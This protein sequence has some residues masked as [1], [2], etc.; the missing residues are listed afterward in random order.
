[1]K[2]KISRDTVKQLIELLEKNDT[3][4]ERFLDNLPTP[5][6]YAILAMALVVRGDYEDFEI[7]Y[8]ESM[9]KISAQDL[10]GH[11]RDFLFLN[12]HLRDA[13]GLEWENFEVLWASDEDD[14][15]KN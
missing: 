2:V 11:L 13:L 1:M 10:T 15:D 4:T 5:Q 8:D 14:E 7:A 3:T 6:K 9:Q 12:C